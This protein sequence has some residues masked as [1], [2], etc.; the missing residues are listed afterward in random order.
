MVLV[1]LVC[2]ASFITAGQDWRV[3]RLNQF[4]KKYNNSQADIIFLIDVSGSV[5]YSGFNTEK[6]FVKSMLSE[7][8][9]QPIAS[10]V[11]VVTFGKYVQENIDYIDYA[12]LDK[13]KCT[14]TKEFAR[15][16]HRRG[17]ATNMQGALA[18]AEKILKGANDRNLKRKHV[19]TVVVLLT[20]GYW[21][22]GGS[23]YHTASVLRD[24]NGYDVE[25]F[26]VGVGTRLTSQLGQVAGDPSNVIIARD[27]S[28]FESLATR[29]RGGKYFFIF[30]FLECL[31]QGSIS[32]PGS[33]AAVPYT[34]GFK[35]L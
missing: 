32:Y 35:N 24:R 19:N 11:A 2:C 9:V 29:I 3:Q 31:A 13:N 10:R 34:P 4:Q 18:Q 1:L 6:E 23:P 27:F 17:P 12:S 22:M 5:S 14:F 33:F 30:V 20:D 26:A 8:S 25:L 16:T 21:N 7:I 28:D 15:V